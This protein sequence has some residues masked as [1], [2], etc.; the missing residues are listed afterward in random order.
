MKAQTDFW[1][2]YKAILVSS[3]IPKLADGRVEEKLK[4]GGAKVADVGCSHG[5]STIVMA[6]TYPNSKFI[7]FDNHHHESIE[8]ATKIAKEEGL[9]EHQIKFEV[10]SSTDYPSSNNGGY[11][12]I[13]FFDS[14]HDMGDPIGAAAHALKALKQDGTVMLV[15]P[16]ANHNLQENLN[17]LGRM[18]GTPLHLLYVFCQRKQAMVWL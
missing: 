14:F 16:F 8:R 11:D 6:K 15:E 9:N 12:L 7:G 1:P 13:A 18:W 2:N 3:W 4:K 10:A 5:I 17:P